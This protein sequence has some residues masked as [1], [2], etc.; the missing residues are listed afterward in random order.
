MCV[1]ERVCMFGGDEGIVRRGLL[2]RN[3][4][5]RF[6]LPM[7]KSGETELPRQN[8]VVFSKGVPSL[9]RILMKVHRLYYNRLV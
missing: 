1:S 9:N 4:M 2:R 5:L 7:F 3:I 6:F 8:I